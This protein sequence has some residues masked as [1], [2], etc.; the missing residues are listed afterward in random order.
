MSR[1]AQ[2]V[3][4]LICLLLAESL[5]SC[6][7]VELQSNRDTTTASHEKTPKVPVSRV[8]LQLI[9]RQEKLPA[10]L[11]AYR[12]VTLY[13]KV[14]GFVQWIGVDR[15]SIVKARQ[16]LVRLSA[17]EL[18]DQRAQSV[19]QAKAAREEQ[20]QARSDLESLAAEQRQTEAQLK[21]ER[22]TYNRLHEASSY[23]GIIAG[24]DLEIAQQKVVADEEKVQSYVKKRKGLEARIRAVADREGSAIHS[25]QSSK[26][27]ESYLQIAAP[28]DGVITERN[29]HEGS[30]VSAPSTGKSTPLL[31]IQQLSLLRLTVPVPEMDVGSIAPGAVVTFNVPAFAGETF[32][33][34]IARLGGALDLATRTMPVE[35]DVTNQTRRLAPGMYAEVIWPV[36]RRRASLLVPKT[37]IVKTTERTFVIRI[38]GGITQWVDVKTGT[39]VDELVEVVGKLDPG[40]A[41]ALR[42][43]DELREGKHVEITESPQEKSSTK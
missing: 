3:Q 39:T 10:D 30:F 1:Y 28:F 31:R 11:L 23:P 26:A 37:A 12:D 7:Q 5:L 20:N 32:T 40:D 2:T 36:V 27:I 4:T 19:D 22:D 33:G 9:Q 18:S 43:T 6:G 34:V 25:A 21:A 14:Q 35:L 16:L 13:P 42:G 8:V 17:P 29:V 41:V 38:R 24:N 15:G